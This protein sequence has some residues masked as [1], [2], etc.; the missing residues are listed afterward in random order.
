[1]EGN[2]RTCAKAGHEHA[3]VTTVRLGANYSDYVASPPPPSSLFE[4]DCK[5]VWVYLLGQIAGGNYTFAPSLVTD[6]CY[7]S[8]L[9]SSVHARKKYAKNYNFF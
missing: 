9:F 4:S 2:H 7:V 3:T 6:H 5:M 8:E 1:M